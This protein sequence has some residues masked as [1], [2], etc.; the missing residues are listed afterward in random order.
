M[1]RSSDSYVPP[2]SYESP[3]RRAEFIVKDSGKRQEFDSGMVRDTDEG[4]PRFDLLVPLGVPFDEQFLTRIAMH[5]TKG[6]IKYGDRN[7]EKANSPEERDRARQSAFR[8]FMQWMAGER[9]EDHAAAA[10]YGLMATETINWKLERADLKEHAIEAMRTEQP[11]VLN[12]SI[13]TGHVHNWLRM[14]LYED[15][16]NPGKL[17]KHINR[18]HTIGGEGSMTLPELITAHRAAHGR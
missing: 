18:E 3:T 11:V 4:K 8:H 10:F 7:W 17:F 16:D 1:P 6:A 9:D 12:D 2:A 14:H 5:M 15:K 13:P